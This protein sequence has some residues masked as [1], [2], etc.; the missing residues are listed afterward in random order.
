MSKRRPRQVD[1]ARHAGVSPAIVSL[2]LNGKIDDKIRIS[3]Q[4]V[5][6]VRASMRELGYMPNPVARSLATGHNRILGV[7]TYEPLFPL[8]TE[9]F[10]FPFLV[11]IEDQAEALDYDLLLFTRSRHHDGRRSVYRDGVNQLLMADGS[12]LFGRDVEASEIERLTL[13]AYPF[14]SIGR[15]D[16]EAPYDYVAADYAGAT[17]DVVEYLVERGHRVIAYLG[18]PDRAVSYRERERGFRQAHDD[19]RLPLDPRRVLFSD[20][21]TLLGEHLDALL[22]AGATALVCENHRLAAALLR[23]ARE[24][25]LAIP[26]D[27]SL[28]LLGEH[29]R[30]SDALASCTTFRIPLYAMGVEAVRL[31]GEALEGRSDH[32]QT[33]LS[34]DFVAGHTVATIDTPSPPSTHRAPDA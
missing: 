18:A 21:E 31:L 6:R 34:C 12:I 11:G 22:A 29:H 20:P 5:E 24:R 28:A 3:P 13:E 15:V 17:R 27:V 19:N 30:P 14:V 33:T 9:S 8:Q 10:Y 26:R 16:S 4:T 23:L 1:V 32:R 7:F 25:R 2:V